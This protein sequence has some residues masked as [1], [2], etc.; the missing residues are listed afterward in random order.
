MFAFVML[1]KRLA[2]ELSGR[3]NR[4]VRVGQYTHFA[5]SFHIY[6]KDLR[7]FE[8]LFLRSVENRTFDNRTYPM[9]FCEPFFEEA[10]PAIKEKIEKLRQGREEER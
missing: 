2:E 7:D 4:E 5:D 1:Q 3:L 9:E 10:R 8:N 6:G